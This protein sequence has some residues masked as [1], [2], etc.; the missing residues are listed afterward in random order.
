MFFDIIEIEVVNQFEEKSFL[1]NSEQFSDFIKN[2]LRVKD[3]K[4]EIKYSEN[5][6]E[7]YIKPFLPAEIFKEMCSNN[8]TLD[9][10]KKLF[11]FEIIRPE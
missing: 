6:P 4:F 11:N 8:P 9:D 5:V 10:F 7:V 3:F 2:E 1:L